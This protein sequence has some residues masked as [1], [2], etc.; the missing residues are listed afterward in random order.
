MY[1]WPILRIRG[2]SMSE[3]KPTGASGPV[4]APRFNVNSF[5]I[6]ASATEVSILGISQVIGIDELGGF[7][8]GGV[9]SFQMG[10]SPAVAKELML[11]LKTIIDNHESQ[12]G[13]LVTPFTQGQSVKP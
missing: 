1:Q 7:E 3:P 11:V 8:V 13:E 2:Y 6:V 9:P 12:I 5:Q 10:L 4:N